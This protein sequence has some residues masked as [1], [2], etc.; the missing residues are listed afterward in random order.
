V[1]R[2]V[3]AT[4]FFRPDE[5]DIAV[6]LVDERLARGDASGYFFVM[7][8]LDQQLV[9]YACYGPIGC[10]LGSFDLYWIAVDPAYQG[11]GLG[12]QLVS[13]VEQRIL[14]AGGRHIYIET[15]GKP[16]YLPTRKFY[17]RCGYEVVAQLADF[18]D[19]GDDKVVW[20]KVL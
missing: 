4:K 9:G 2:V 13:A 20:R 11:R 5:V 10:T 8:E 14:D 15:S 19:R 17:Q 12:A 6:E 7:A 18:Y 1:R 3:E 16:Q